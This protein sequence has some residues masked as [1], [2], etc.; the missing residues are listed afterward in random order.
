MV[1]ELFEMARSKKACLIFFDEIDAIGGARFDDGAGG[2]NEV[3]RTMLELINQLDGFDPRGNIKVLMATNRPD[4]LDPALMRPGRLD[5][6]VE[7]GLP[8]LEGRTHI[9][10]IHARSMSVERDIRFEL[11]ARLCPNSTGAEIRWVSELLNF[12]VSLCK[13]MTFLDFR[14]VCTE[15]GMFAIRARRKVAT[16]KDFLEAVNKVI[17]S[18]AKFSATPRYMTYN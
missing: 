3:Q 2:D 18:Y 8:D 16:E 7:F 9:F 17:K 11:L 5:R 4:T 10:K 1:R 13:L 6:K 14:S 15:A 12:F